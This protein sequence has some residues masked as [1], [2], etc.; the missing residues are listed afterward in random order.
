MMPLYWPI[1]EHLN[2]RPPPS[3]KAGYSTHNLST[4]C[5]FNLAHGKSPQIEGHFLHAIA[6]C[7]HYPYSQHQPETGR[8]KQEPGTSSMCPLADF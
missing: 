8:F 4:K 6:E 2:Y 1:E 7:P 3:L 5:R